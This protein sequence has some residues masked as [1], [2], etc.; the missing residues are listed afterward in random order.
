MLISVQS[1]QKPYRKGV[2]ENSVGGKVIVPMNYDDIVYQKYGISAINP[3]GT[4]DGFLY[5]GS[6]VMQSGKKILF[7]KN[8]ILVFTNPKNN[9]CYIFNYDTGTLACEYEFEAVLFFCG[10]GN[11]AIQYNSKTDLR[12]MFLS[13][14]YSKNGAYL[15]NLVCGKH[16]GKWGVYNLEKHC[17]HSP[18][19]HKTMVQCKNG[20]I[21][22][23]GNDN[24]VQ[25]L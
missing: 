24:S 10:S 2:V 23:R 12:K 18:F 3:D 6:Q 13:P 17:I 8:H 22:V 11:Q 7:L 25:M 19:I 16:S 5:T 9:H 21:A 15:E 1:L 20:Q 4:E 14:D